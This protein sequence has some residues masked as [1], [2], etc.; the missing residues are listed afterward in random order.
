MSRPPGQ[1]QQ[2]PV[3][4]KTVP[5]R[6]KTQKWQ[7]AKTYNYDGDEWGGYDPYDEYGD[8]DDTASPE[9]PQPQ[10][11]KPPQRQN[12]FDAGDEKR[13]FSSGY[14]PDGRGISPAAVSSGSGGRPSGDY[15]SQ[16]A[17]AAPTGA[18][19][20]NDYGTSPRGRNFTNP[21]QVP[22][23]LNTR[24]SPARSAGGTAFPPRKSSMSQASS[25]AQ[26]PTPAD[27][28]NIDKPLPF[29]RPSD[30]YRR[31]AEEKERERQSMDS[32]RPSMDSIQRDLATSPPM[33]PT[34]ASM[35]RARSLD[36][37]AEQ[38]E[39]EPVEQAQHASQ[40]FERS[41]DRS[42]S[43][44]MQQEAEYQP[45]SSLQPSTYGDP[46]RNA[47]KGLSPVLP[48]VSRISGFGSD[49]L[50]GVTAR[51]T[52]PDDE[53]SNNMHSP[54]AP[55]DQHVQS[56]IARVFNAP[57]ENPDPSHVSPTMSTF[58]QSAPVATR[59]PYSQDHAADVLAE[60][61][62]GAPSEATRAPHGRDPAAEIL[63]E[64]QYGAPVQATRASEGH[65]PA[66][67]NLAERQHSTRMQ[68]TRAQEGH[69][70]AADILAERQHAV[71]VH[72]IG[73]QEQ[74][75]DLQHQPSSGFRSVVD[76]AFERP[77][78]NSVPPTPISRDDSQSIG[79]G[80][81]VSRSNT[82]STAGISPIMSRVPSAATAQQRQQ[83][84]DAQ[85]PPIAEEPS[86][87]RTPTQSRPASGNYLAGSSPQHQIP[88]KPSPSGHSR[89][90]SSESGSGAA[91]FQRGYRR[92]LDPPS[93]D[94]S[95]ARTPGMEDGSGR[96]VS[97]PM[98]AETVGSA[99]A[100][101]VEDQ[102]AEMPTAS[103]EPA[104]ETPASEI[105]ELAPQSEYSA[106]PTTGRGRSG[107]DYS[108]RE[109][110]LANAV[111]LSPATPSYSPP[112]AEDQ[113]ATQ[114]LF[115][116]THNGTPGSPAS[117]GFGRP[118][119]PGIAAGGL[120][121][122]ASP[123]FARPVSPGIAAQGLGIAR[124][125][126]PNG[127][128]TTGRDSPAKGRVR[129]IAEKYTSL[130]DASRR[131]STASFGSGKSSWSNFR[132]G[133]EEELAL[134]RKGT[135]TSSLAADG[136]TDDD[137]TYQREEE[138]EGM[139]PQYEQSRDRSNERGLPMPGVGGEET[140]LRPGAE[141][142]ASFRPHLPGEWVSYAP[143][144]AGEAPPAA[145]SSFE[146]M[147][148]QMRTQDVEPE[149]SSPI[150]PQASH[151]AAEHDEPIDLTPTTK[152]HR[153]PS[154]DF[155]PD[156][157]QNTSALT[158]QVKDAGAA[159]GA[160]LMAMGG[161]T[162][163]AR[164][165]GSAQPAKPVDHPEMADKVPY[166]D[167]SSYLRPGLRPREE[168]GATDVTE[169][170]APPSVASEV[171]PTP[172]AKDTPAGSH[173]A[174]A[175][176]GNQE[177]EAGPG[178]RPISSY[179]SGVVAPLRMG[180][181]HSR[182]GSAEP[183]AH[184][185]MVG[186][187]RV[188]PSLSTDT[189][190]SDMESDRLRK[191]IVRS[192][193]P[194]PLQRESIL[195]DD[196][197]TQ[198]AL[199]A[200]ENSRRV[201][202]GLPALPA[203][204]IKDASERG[205]GAEMEKQMP[206]MLDQRFSWENRPQQAGVLTP[207]RIREPESPEVRPE[208][209]YER[210]RSRGLHIVNTGVSEE[211]TPVEEKAANVPLPDPVQD[212]AGGERGLSGSLPVSA[213]GFVSPMTN[214]QENLALPPLSERMAAGEDGEMQDLGPSPV[215]DRQEQESLGD[216][217]PR[218]PS[219][220]QS[221]LAA[222]GSA[223]TPPPAVESPGGSS[224]AASPSG[225]KRQSAGQR[226]LPMREIMAIKSSPD[227][228]RTYNDTRQQFADTDTGLSSWL[229]GMLMQ[230][231]EYAS[232]STPGVY[233]APAALGTTGTFSGRHKHGPSIVTKLYGGDRKTSAA[234]GSAA[235]GS[236]AGHL[237]SMPRA[238]EAM[239]M[240]K[241]QQK[242]KDLMKNASVLGGK[243][244]AG[245]K[246]LF[247]KGKSRWGVKRD[248]GGDGKAPRTPAPAAPHLLVYA[249]TSSPASP[250]SHSLAV[251]TPTRDSSTSPSPIPRSSTQTPS[252][253]PSSRPLSRTFS[254][255][256]ERS[257]S[258]STNRS[259]SRPTSL[260][261]TNP[262]LITEIDDDTSLPAPV[263][264]D[265]WGGRRG[266]SP[267][268]SER[269]EAWNEPDAA[270]PRTP[271]RE[272]SGTPA[273]LGVLPS[274][275]LDTFSYLELSPIKAVSPQDTVLE[276]RS[277]EDAAT[278]ESEEALT[279]SGSDAPVV[280][281]VE[282]LIGTGRDIVH[283]DRNP[284]ES[285]TIVAKEPVTL[286]RPKIA[287]QTE[288]AQTPSLP[289]AI[290]HDNI[291]A[292]ASGGHAQ[293][294]QPQHTASY[295]QTST[296]GFTPSAAEPLQSRPQGQ[297][298]VSA[299]ASL[300]SQ[301]RNMSRGSSMISSRPTTSVTTKSPAFAKQPTD[302]DDELYVSTP[303]VANPRTGKLADEDEMYESTPVVARTPAPWR[304]SH[305]MF[306]VPSATAMQT[307]SA[308]DE[309]QANPGAVRGEHGV[310]DTQSR[311]LRTVSDPVTEHEPSQSTGASDWDRRSD[312]SAEEHLQAASED[313]GPEDYGTLAS[314]HSSVSSLGSPDTIIGNRA[315]MIRMRPSQG[316]APTDAGEQPVMS[317]QAVPAGPIGSDLPPAHK[318]ESVAELGRSQ[319]PSVADQQATYSSERSLTSEQERFMGRSYRGQ[320]APVERAMSYM[321]LGEDLT[322][323]PN[324][325]VIDM[326]D[327][328][329]LEAADISR[330]GGPPTGT[331]PF[332]KQPLFRNSGIAAPP[333][334]YENLRSSR[335][336]TTTPITLHSRQPSGMSSL[337]NDA[338]DRRSKR[339]SA[340][341]RG[342]DPA[343]DMATA[344]PPPH[345]ITP[346]YG[347]EN[348]DMIDAETAGATPLRQENDKQRKRR[349]GLWDAFKRSPSVSRTNFSRESSVGRLDSRSDL[350]TNPAMI[351]ANRA[352]ENATKPKTLQKPQRAVSAAAPPTDLK[353]KPRFS[354]LG[355][356]FGRSN[357][358]G[359]N[360]EKPKK[361]VK[362]QPPERDQSRRQ[363]MA[364]SGSVRG[365]DA[366]EAMRRQQNSEVQRR[367]TNDQYA[368]TTMSSPYQQAPPT[369]T[370]RGESSAGEV[371]P[372]SQG[373]YGPSENQ[374]PNAQTQP[375]LEPDYMQRS[376]RPP[377]F[378]R[379]HSQG[380]ERGLQEANIPE[381]FRPTQA[382]YG[383]APVPIGPPPE[384]QP[385]VVYEPPALSR[386][387]TLPTR[388]PYWN[389]QPSGSSQMSLTG[390]P[391]QRQT[392][393]G[394]G[395]YQSS[396]PVYGQPEPRRAQPS[397]EDSLP[398]ISPVQTYMAPQ[399]YPQGGG[400]YVGGI[401]EQRARS[402][403][404][405]YADQQ[406]P[407]SI[408]MPPNGDASQ[409][410]SRMPSWTAPVGGP[411]QGDMY[412]IRQG[413]PGTMSPPPGGMR[414]SPYGLPMSPQSPE[415]QQP[416]MYPPPQASAPTMPQGPMYATPQARDNSNV[417]SGS[418]PSPP[419]T[420]QSPVQH[421]QSPYGAPAQHSYGPPS[422]PQQRRPPQQPRYYVQ[423]QQQ[424]QPISRPP[425][426]GRPL[427]YQRT[428]SGYTGRRDDAA[429][430][431]Q[432]L[433]MRGA[434]Y[435]GQEWSPAI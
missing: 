373:W 229:S 374:S 183:T 424:D 88:R 298:K 82:N 36:P 12:S 114:Q 7:Q 22:P 85:V 181:G 368:D 261:L 33:S 28:T 244:Q 62:Y 426:A 339:L 389:R 396:V 231:P 386:M 203:A 364:S 275:G 327:E 379:L 134:K 287:D 217:E 400:Q 188:L 191:E 390:P 110:D 72:A 45:L 419:Y 212:S 41:P 109:S 395:E 117:A 393:S 397:R 296:A 60:R 71:P 328:P 272:R 168:S 133:S 4:F 312:V 391:Q 216:S 205:P 11:A 30:I 26:E 226:L 84:R 121:S 167:V 46:E 55:V 279:A 14:G 219:Y 61:Q 273:R 124:A 180:G 142:Q 295:D 232:L 266:F 413:H 166:G 282:A 155:T 385:P 255:L 326:G 211:K 27:V 201:E 245:A 335:S 31:M 92:S 324:Q 369:I 293:S 239:D 417:N 8:Y 359:H 152:K 24:A 262:D 309:V 68:A 126:T 301:Q 138:H 131:N 337:G 351:A 153:L 313:K 83:D 156:P 311:A 342:P 151:I 107:T 358:Q 323:A 125:S 306:E 248:S 160:S 144:P 411:P 403:A 367:D 20:S 214:S 165:F 157:Q 215:S 204:E 307:P 32:S 258:K 363:G 174:V 111:N 50:H 227:R 70:P 207:P 162:S 315:S 91:A 285:E 54:P 115:L 185:Q 302:E 193:G 380:F 246:G 195:E 119:S 93:H 376:Q 161:L 19:G 418:Y 289:A 79:S 425:S 137:G 256:R 186:R 250:S 355:S 274:P 208:A 225:T 147:E 118:V 190:A 430:S 331:P 120:T 209:P 189:G 95:P 16:A 221:D 388:Q 81:G 59:R 73:R 78:D 271:E 222:E 247:A 375:A 431:E 148:P 384:H 286:G 103:L 202:H 89:N 360:S 37:V 321:P 29:I 347:L 348:L 252:S 338:G 154:G 132:G 243:A 415:T 10:Y 276:D 198:D 406:T 97:T 206:R 404:S 187:P 25:P 99:E 86:S 116:R 42:V 66:A 122:P 428:P 163:H 254:R 170:S 394:P 235:G 230:N 377:Q 332:Q 401:D 433:M 314:R 34:S 80:S 104:L 325:E 412:P 392:S 238:G 224:Q 242:G 387:P 357:T 269:T 53:V 329:P 365:Y 135:G 291:T 77:D 67:D 130:D 260:I 318:E 352:R 233:K 51:D 297:R 259:K 5:G 172:P 398:T 199:D 300:P 408:A 280:P 249:S 316:I 281:V 136:A 349:S 405:G 101:D 1:Q 346:Q 310:L 241:V 177:L 56:T 317:A 228:I 17:P 353:K 65:D 94:N 292:A 105:G 350:V 344:A 341:F 268:A 100:P 422:H 64:R 284:L 340:L 164:D 15:A 171:P 251:A 150:T 179:F 106:L 414:H 47:K 102:A 378:R 49:F 52:T 319:G 381:A 9:P 218:L 39:R 108:V 432:E 200:P 194:N 98:A 220:Y 345:A 182:E 113:K 264:A 240:D 421:Y 141:S 176:G 423:Q 192:L 6:N 40:A 299:L 146:E 410:S 288:H 265:A 416:Y 366:Y 74:A 18:R 304:T 234:G 13:T 175:G 63:A 237:P 173:L 290:D 409:R 362:P 305:G 407:W 143:T 336:G 420:P 196:E 139:F 44:D 69:D 435:P 140:G 75:T 270:L 210:P 354:R 127:G 169:M 128:S 123:G 213:P 294:R 112:V 257:R 21:E 371:R 178:G 223:A 402:P 253:V 90:V 382:S 48:P 399:R 361:L 320:V 334:E 343:P 236:E 197:R 96:R 429:V 184:G 38:H 277:A 87:A 427:T 23:P 149:L 303:T 43:S 129:E 383:K 3:S 76:T 2:T 158:Q 159:L 283:D 434:S 58:G 57:V 330:F 308:R 35:D 372:P 356:L 267:L 322:G 145:T 370:T 333:S 263:G 278:G